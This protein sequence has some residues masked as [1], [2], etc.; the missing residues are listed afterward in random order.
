MGALELFNRPANATS[1]SEGAAGKSKQLA[2]GGMQG[3]NSWKKRK[4]G[5]P[6]P[7]SGVH[8]YFFKVYALDQMLRVK[9]YGKRSLEK[10]MKGHILGEAQLMGTYP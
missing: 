6:C 5:G 3:Y 1:L 4:F 7:P 2:D 9:S 10:A 8:R